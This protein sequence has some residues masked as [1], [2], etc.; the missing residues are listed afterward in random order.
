M[1]DGSAVN[2]TRTD[3]ALRLTSEVLVRLCGFAS[4]PLLAR[5]LGSDGYG[6]VGGSGAIVSGFAAVATLGLSYHV[7]RIVGRGETA[8][9]RTLLRRLII[10]AGTSGLFWAMVAVVMAPWLNA[11]F[12]GHPAGA[13]AIACASGSLVAM[14]LDGVLLEWLRQRERFRSLSLLQGSM[15]LAQL[16]SLVA[17]V[18]G[19]AGPAAILA[20]TSGLQL[21][22]IALMALLIRHSSRAVD[23]MASPLELTLADCLRD[24]ASLTLGSLGAWGLGQGGRLMLGDATAIGGY[25]VAAALASLASIVGNAAS[26]PLTAALVRAAATNR[27]RAAAVAVK[28]FSSTFHLLTL[29]G[30]A[31]TACLAEDGIRYLTGF[32]GLGLISAVLLIAGWIEMSALPLVYT[33]WARGWASRSRNAQIAAATGSLVGSAILARPLG[34]LGVAVA[35][36][37]GQAA[38]LLLVGWGLRHAHFPWQSMVPRRAGALLLSATLASMTA[39]ALR[40]DS[41]PSLFAAGS[42]AMAVAALPLV[43]SG[44]GGTI[45]GR[46]RPGHQSD[47]Q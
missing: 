31:I 34:P 21:L 12:L 9:A 26:M 5:A 28:R 45:W 33:L 30:I 29:P 6:V 35:V 4:L 19:G 32:H 43:I 39:I 20:I 27:P 13:L 18:I 40:G 47:Y 24:G 25:A 16:A 36:L 41:W 15:A 44:A 1:G 2:T 7:G 10:L 38:M 46:R 3:V 37:C 11:R 23:L 14:A 17:A 22:R 42:A 8:T